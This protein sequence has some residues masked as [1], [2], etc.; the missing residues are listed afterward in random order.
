[1]KVGRVK[2][3]EGVEAVRARYAEPQLFLPELVRYLIWKQM[4]DVTALFYALH[5]KV[6]E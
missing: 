2:V 6:R 5:D 1:M 3:A 4:S